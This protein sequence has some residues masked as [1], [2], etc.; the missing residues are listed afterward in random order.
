MGKYED[1]VSQVR[2]AGMED[3]ADELEKFSATN[4][5]K[6][7]EER[8]EFE[9]R[10]QAAEA[11]VTE[12]ESAPKREAAFKDYGVDIDGL[13]PAEREALKGFS[14]QSTDPTREEVAA[15]V[16]KY[17]LPLIEGSTE[18]DEEEA[19]AAARVVSQARASGSGRVAADTTLSA[20]DM[21]DWSTEKMARFRDKHP[22]EFEALKRGETLVGVLP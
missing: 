3:E 18:S 5:R 1:I 8:D 13:R 11:R 21:Q 14:P 10:V 16:E 17:D 20:A 12:L 19:P 9:R 6:K 7:A 22:D 4:L 15:F 2:D